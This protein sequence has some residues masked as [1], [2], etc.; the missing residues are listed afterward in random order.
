VRHLR[1]VFTNIGPVGG[2]ASGRLPFDPLVA[3]FARN[4]AFA[5]DVALS[6][7]QRAEWRLFPA[8]HRQKVY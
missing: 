1:T 2:V 5:K 8:E 3:L 6:G 4:V 7:N